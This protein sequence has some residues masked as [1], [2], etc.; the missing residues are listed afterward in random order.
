M[1]VHAS[2]R[3]KKEVD[4]EDMMVINTKQ[5][6]IGNYG[7]ETEVSCGPILHR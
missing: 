3:F 4:A 7:P 1:L 5:C 6:Q 2:K